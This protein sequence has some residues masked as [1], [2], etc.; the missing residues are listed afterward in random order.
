MSRSSFTTNPVSL[1]ALLLSCGSGKVQLPDFQRSWVWAEDRILSLIASISRGFPVGALM[2]LASK[3]GGPE[4]FA[5]RPIEGAPT[6]ATL[7]VPEQLLLDGQ[8]RLTSLFHACLQKAVVQTITP[9]K[10]VVRRWFYINIGKALQSDADRDD[11]ILAIPEDRKIKTNFDKDVVL[12]LS[13]A[14]A[15]YEQMYFPLNQ[16][17]DWDAWQDGFGDYW[18]AKDDPGKRHLFRQFKEKVLLNFKSYQVPVIALGHETTH[19]AV[20][21]VFEKVNTG[22]KPL[23]A[24]E[25]LTAM[26][27]AKGHKLRDD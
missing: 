10:K 21:L 20:C 1:E 22:G 12:D 3:P 14:T 13:T 16:V 9:K 15:E 17:F 27:A 5:R 19:E 11:A 24:F 4:V 6:E 8:Q 2:T 7:V 18:L 26:Y 23:D 25:L